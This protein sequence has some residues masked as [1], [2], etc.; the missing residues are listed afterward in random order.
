[1]A[2]WYGVV[3]LGLVM[4]TVPLVTGLKEMREPEDG[5]NLEEELSTGV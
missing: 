4:L 2:G 1:L 3:T 5:A